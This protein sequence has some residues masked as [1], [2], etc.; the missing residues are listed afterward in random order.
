M[1]ENFQITALGSK[2]GHAFENPRVIG[3]SKILL[4]P[5][6]STDITIFDWMTETLTT[7]GSVAY[8]GSTTDAL[9][10]TITSTGSDGKT[11]IAPRRANRFYRITPAMVLEEFGSPISSEDLDLFE[12]CVYYDGCIYYIPFV[13]NYLVKYNIASDTWDYTFAPAVGCFKT[14]MLDGQYLYLAPYQSTLNIVRINLATGS[15]VNVGSPLPSGFQCRVGDVGSDGCLYTVDYTSPSVARLIKIDPVS[16]DWSYVG[17][18]MGS[19]SGYLAI[20]L[21]AIGNHIYIFNR[22]RY[23]SSTYYGLM[24]YNVLDETITSVGGSPPDWRFAYRSD[25][26]Y[27]GASTALRTGTGQ[28]SV[29]SFNN[30]TQP[31]ESVLDL[32]SITGSYTYILCGDYYSGKMY[33]FPRNNEGGTY[34]RITNL[35]TFYNAPI[36]GASF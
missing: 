25:F 8:S 20:R 6:Y 4:L 10:G 33:A 28:F 17:P 1:Y 36:I 30:P 15:V 14:F 34:Y 12:S 32:Q 13:H 35:S 22:D 21:R 26:H 16:L 19:L 5:M 3:V 29:F 27:A 7:L 31:S 9:L 11:Y 24:R 2:P 23:T 18:D